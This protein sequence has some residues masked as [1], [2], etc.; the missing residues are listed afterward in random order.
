MNKSNADEFGNF[1]RMMHKLIKVPH[2]KIK[3]KLDQE[4][5]LKKNE[6]RR[7]RKQSNP[8]STG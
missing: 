2:S 4:K 7:G 1:D 6:K 8:N 3:A 5:E